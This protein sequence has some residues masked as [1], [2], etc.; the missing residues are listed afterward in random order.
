MD[1]DRR[2]LHAVLNAEEFNALR[3]RLPRSARRGVDPAPP[4][5]V[6]IIVQIVSRDDCRLASV[7]AH[8]PAQADLAQE[9]SRLEATAYGMLT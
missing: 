4:G 7:C 8:V 9:L 5:H 1:T 2:A 6:G 3:L